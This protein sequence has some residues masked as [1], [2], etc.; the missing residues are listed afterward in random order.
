M[1]ILASTSAARQAILRNAGVPFTIEAPSVDERRLAREHPHWSPTETAAELALAK[2]LEVSY[3]R[4]EALVI[5]A[6]QVLACDDIAFHKPGGIDE[7]RSQLLSL[8]GRSHTLISAVVCARH[9]KLQW[10]T[11]EAATLHMRQ[12]SDAFL[13][14]YLRANSQRAMASVGGYQIEAMGI[15]LFDHIDGDHFCILGLPLLPLLHHLRACG[16]LTS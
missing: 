14:T 12:F 1:I 6:D 11:N 9:G 8:R 7:C 4:P 2:A 3:R 15:Q 5:G 13:D 10:Q 16:E